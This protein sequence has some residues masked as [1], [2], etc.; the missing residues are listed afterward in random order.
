MIPL[1][2]ANDENDFPN[3]LSA[4]MDR[5]HPDDYNKVVEAFETH[6]Q[7]YSGKTPYDIE[8]RIK[9]K[10]G[11]YRVMHTFGATMRDK[12]GVPIR[13]AGAVE[14]VTDKVHHKE[15]LEKSVAY[16]KAILNGIDSYI[17]VTVPETGELLFL[18]D[19]IR[20]AFGVKSDGVG[21]FCYKLLHGRDE[22]CDFCPYFQLEKEPKKIIKWENQ[23][24]DGSIHSKT[25]M[26]IDWPDGR[27]AHLEFGIDITETRLAQK[28]LEQREKMLGALNSAAIVLL[29]QKT[30]MFEKAMTAGVSIISGIANIDRVSISRNIQ[31]PDG[32][33][34]SQIY[35][36][37]KDIGDA[38]DVLK[39]FQNRPYSRDIP[40]WEEVLASGECINGP[41]RL[42]PEGELLKN[43]GC[44]TILAIPI[45]IESVFW[46]FVLFEDQTEERTFT[47]DEIDI[48]R[49]ASFMLANAVIRNEEAKIIREADEH[50]KLMLNSN[51]LSC[52]LWNTDN[53]VIECN[54]A[55]LTLFGLPDKSR[56]PTGFYDY[57]P[58]YQPNGQ[59]SEEIL[60]GLL[61][62]AFEK[63]SCVFECMLQMV[64]GT[65]IPAEV[66]LVRVKDKNGYV[67]AGYIRDLREQKRMTAEIERRSAA[68]R[69]FESVKPNVRYFASSGCQIL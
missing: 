36:W 26:L 13:T 35:R 6:L 37:R 15:I 29:S 34:A 43:L 61:S 28:A 57:V 54:D 17:G 23:E 48:L 52:T 5:L 41:I 18:N 60:N 12:D 31:K 40:R 20:D 56:L 30:E 10:S 9:T 1:I 32:V 33:Y 25:A 27:K 62:T 67:V 69:S 65:P 45:L 63:G 38:V 3:T 39:E 53:K 14:D 47:G 58:E 66:S 51:P 68:Q 4:W 59:R 11:E 64:N 2:P 42:M 7:D 24:K 49:S 44:L 22:R 21:D 19:K 8:Y 55:V 50:A 46:G 16:F